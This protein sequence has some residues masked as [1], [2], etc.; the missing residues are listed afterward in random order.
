M[1]S[2]VVIVDAVVLATLAM[3]NLCRAGSVNRPVYRAGSAQGSRLCDSTG[4]KS[5]LGYAR[6]RPGANP[7]R[8]P[9]AIV[10]CDGGR[11]DVTASLPDQARRGQHGCSAGRVQFSVG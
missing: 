5:A 8:Q 10:E 7:T 4:A 6:G 2:G 3:V 1:N 9:D 11:A